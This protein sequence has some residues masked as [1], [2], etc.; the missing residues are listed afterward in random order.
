M[1]AHFRFCKVVECWFIPQWPLTFF[2]NSRNLQNPR[3]VGYFTMGYK[4]TNEG[5][6]KKS[7]RALFEKTEFTFLGPNVDFQKSSQNSSKLTP[8]HSIGTTSVPTKFQLSRYLNTG[9]IAIQKSEVFAGKSVNRWC[10]N[11]ELSAPTERKFSGHT[12][13]TNRL[14]WYQF[15]QNL[16]TF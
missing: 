11:S 5:K 4:V 13:G 16:P 2:W 7:F 14:L 10:Q 3:L 15:E 1:T 8:N 12:W 6:T 9:A